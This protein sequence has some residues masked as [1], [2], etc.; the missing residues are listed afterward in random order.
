ML[1]FY[2][3]LFIWV[4][5]RKGQSRGPIKRSSDLGTFSSR[6]SNYLKGKAQDKWGNWL[7]TMQGTDTMFLLFLALVN[8]CVENQYSA[9]VDQRNKG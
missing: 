2:L 5:D 3:V 6:R 9:A 8:C 7:F 4:G 1:S